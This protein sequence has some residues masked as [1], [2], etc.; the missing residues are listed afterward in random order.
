M[1]EVSSTNDYLKELLSNIKPLAEATAIMARNQTH[2]RGQR[3][4]TWLTSKDENLTFSFALYPKNFPSSKSF[5][6]NM[7]VCLGIQT[8]LKQYGL[9]ARI[10]WP[11][12][13]YINN[14]K[15]CG[16]LIENK[17][18]G[19]NIHTSIVGIGVNA[20][21]ISFPDSIA[22]KTTSM[23]LESIAK[24][25]ID[26]QNLCIALLTTIL[27]VYETSARADGISL[28]RYY[29]NQLFRKGIVAAF[30][31]DGIET[32]AEI[33]KVDEQGRL[34]VLVDN[35]IRTFDNKEITFII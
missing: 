35:Q 18:A 21:Q 27:T 1:D 6:L 14:R 26:L 20:N 28:L 7:I 17:L 2:G 33:K 25:E 31:I 13:I 8:G 12:D 30:L 11:N 19:A 9:D 16:I 32:M 5:D 24:D 34:H 22:G 23:R 3:G 29:N 15:I 10:K 4:S